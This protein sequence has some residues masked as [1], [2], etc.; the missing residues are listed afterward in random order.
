MVHTGS[1]ND[2][3]PVIVDNGN[4]ELTRHTGQPEMCKWMQGIK[5]T[6]RQ[7]NAIN[8]KNTIVKRVK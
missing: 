6:E 5:G 4:C 3:E 1:N 8:R 7:R 2:Y